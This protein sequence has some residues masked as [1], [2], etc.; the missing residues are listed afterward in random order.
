MLLIISL[1]ALVAG[2]GGKSPSK[3][4]IAQTYIAEQERTAQTAEINKRIFTSVQTKREPS[5]PVLGPG[6]LLHVAV[7]E[8]PELTS[9]VRVGARGFVTLALLGEVKVGGLTARQVETEIENLYRAKYIKNPHV[10][11][12]VK[13]H[14]S[15]KI[16]LV[17]QVKNPGTYEMPT[18]LRLMDALALAGG[19]TDRAGT[20]AQIRRVGEMD[21]G[22]GSCVVDLDRLINKGDAE[23]NI[24]IHGGDIIFIPETGTYYVDGA[25]RRP[26]AYPLKTDTTVEQA[27]AMAGGL[28][29]YG[30]PNDVCLVRRGADGKRKAIPLDLEKGK[31]CEFKLKDGDILVA[32]SSF[33]GKLTTGMGINIGLPF[34]GVGFYNPD[35]Q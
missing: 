31:D 19:L 17:G 15:Q 16:T 8:A 5:D 11:V 26:G 7:F 14:F 35:R 3:E 33:W 2:C 25:V 1:L 29:P 30:D 4:E 6:D 32:D 27:I 21:K 10:T 12:F 34:F 23:L 22:P 20:T 9:E 13:E 28:R 18:R 24:P